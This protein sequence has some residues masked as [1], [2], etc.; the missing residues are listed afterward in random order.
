MVRYS[1]ITPADLKTHERKVSNQYI[2]PPATE[3]HIHDGEA[4]PRHARQSARSTTPRT[5]WLCASSVRISIQC[6]AK[7][8][9]PVQVACI[10]T[11]RAV[12]QGP[13]K[14]RQ[15]PGH[16]PASGRQQPFQQSPHSPAALRADNLWRANARASAADSGGGCRTAADGGGSALI[17]RDMPTACALSHLQASSLQRYAVGSVSDCPASYKSWDRDQ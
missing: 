14:C 8:V 2:A 9:L 7:V 11:N 6:T 3:P 4:Q 5:V 17:A 12:D 1:P 10:V 13:R 15:V 16:C